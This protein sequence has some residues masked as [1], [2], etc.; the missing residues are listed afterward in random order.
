[1]AKLSEQILQKQS[2]KQINVRKKQV[3]SQ[4]QTIAREDA[5]EALK[6]K[7]EVTKHLCLLLLMKHTTPIII[8]FPQM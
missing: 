1:M 7:R 8:L 5:R 6:R 4:T 2:G 3:R